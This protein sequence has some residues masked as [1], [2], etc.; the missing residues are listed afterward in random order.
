MQIAADDQLFTV[1]ICP[2]S[3][4]TWHTHMTNNKT[5]K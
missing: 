4:A 1:P 2:T 3:M 5:L